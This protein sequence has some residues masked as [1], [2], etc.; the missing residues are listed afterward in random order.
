MQKFVAQTPAPLLPSG[1]KP[2]EAYLDFATVLAL[3]RK[4]W[5]FGHDNASE[6][7]NPRGVTGLVSLT[8]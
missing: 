7:A 3:R 6:Q 4:K 8:A 2:E 1:I 5:S